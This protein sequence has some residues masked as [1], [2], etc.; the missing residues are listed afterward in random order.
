MLIWFVEKISLS[1]ST[2]VLKEYLDVLVVV[3]VASAPIIAL[4]YLLSHDE[5]IMSSQ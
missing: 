1:I 3:L 2:Y 4:N 5:N